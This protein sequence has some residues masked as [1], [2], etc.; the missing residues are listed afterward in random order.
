MLKTVLSI[1]GINLIQKESQKSITA[2]SFFGG[3]DGEFGTCPFPNALFCNG[4]VPGHVCCNGFCVLPTHP[5]CQ[6]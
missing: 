2:G 5:Q 4:N 6:H 3:G 1:K